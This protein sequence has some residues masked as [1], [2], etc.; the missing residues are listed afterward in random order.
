MQGPSPNRNERSLS[1][2]VHNLDVPKL[3]ISIQGSWASPL[4]FGPST[5][6]YVGLRVLIIISLQVWM[7]FFLLTKKKIWMDVNSYAF[8]I[9]IKKK[10][11]NN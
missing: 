11:N 5:K 2:A 3:S 7:D 1:F 9:T 6:A 8:T 10:L 4:C